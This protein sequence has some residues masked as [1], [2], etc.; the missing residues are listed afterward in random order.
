MF[1]KL[2][3][4]STNPLVLVVAVALAYFAGRQTAP[5]EVKTVTVTQKDT[6]E[7]HHDQ[8][9]IQQKVDIQEFLKV[10]RQ[11][12]AKLDKNWSKK[13]TIT[14]DG[15]KIVEESG[16]SHAE[17]GA[18]TNTDAGKKTTADTKGTSTSDGGSKTSEKT[19]TSTTTSSVKPYTFGWGLTLGSAYDVRS[20]NIIK[21][22][23]V[24]PGIPDSLAAGVYVEQKLPLVPVFLN[25]SA[26]SQG[27]VI[28]FLRM[29]LPTSL[30]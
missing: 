19:S 7:F 29:P 6:T 12:F 26:N 21:V 10:F 27:T 30:R 14:P 11:E 25:I 1:Q 13:T 2:K 3:S 23:S 22:P 24:V 18:T 8:T 15:K 17:S 20:G 5:V 28:G 9:V 16:S 4:V